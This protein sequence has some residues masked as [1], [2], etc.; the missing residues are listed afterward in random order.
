MA[1]DKYATHTLLEGIVS[2]NRI[3]PSAFVPCAWKEEFIGKKKMEIVREFTTK[4]AYPLVMK[5]A[6]GSQGVNVFK[7]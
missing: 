2:S 4:H 3:I 7:V 1:R 5:D 6:H